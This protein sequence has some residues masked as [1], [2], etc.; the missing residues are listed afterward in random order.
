MMALIEVIVRDWHLSKTFRGDEHAISN[1]AFDWTNTV[2]LQ[3]IDTNN[4][5]DPF[6]IDDIMSTATHII[7]FEEEDKEEKLRNV[8][9]VYDKGSLN[10]I[11]GVYLT[12]AEAEEAIYTECEDYAAEVIMTDDPEDV[13]GREFEFPHDYWVLMNDVAKACRIITTLLEE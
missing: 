13:F 3:Y 6:E 12:L 2:I 4:I 5:T 7:T 9:V 8:Y 10:P 11:L 1:E